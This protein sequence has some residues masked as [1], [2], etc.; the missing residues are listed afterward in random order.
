M[1]FNNVKLAMRYN[2][3][4]FIEIFVSILTFEKNVNVFCL[5][6]TVFQLITGK[7]LAER[8]QKRYLLV[9]IQRVVVI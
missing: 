3:Q 9:I 4:K 5:T 6:N 8:G 7:L 2:R 1:H